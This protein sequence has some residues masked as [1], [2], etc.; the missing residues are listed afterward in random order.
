[1]DIIKCREC[2]TEN[3]KDFLY[4]KNCG[5]KL[6]F[7]EESAPKGNFVYEDF[8]P[9]ADDLGVENIN[10][11]PTDQI[12]LFVGKKAHY[13]LPKFNQMA[14]FGK[15]T[16]W[17]FA[18]SI[19]GLLFGP[20]GAALWCFYRKIYKTAFILLLVGIL[21]T[22]ITAALTYDSVTETFDF[23][24]SFSQ[25]EHEKDA[26]DL[27]EE[28]VPKETAKTALAQNIED[29][30]SLG[31]AI[32]MGLFANYIYMNH[33]TDSIKKYRNSGLD[34]RY[35]KLGLASLGGTSGG[36][37]ALGIIL[38]IGVENLSTIIV[39]TMHLLK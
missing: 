12:A 20:L 9:N 35:Y 30:F 29:V 27:L 26:L 17:N 5:A 28:F 37:L 33:C 23:I 16:S 25:K 39:L 15:K 2:G 14:I 7:D 38:F 19:L 24:L 34:Q 4:C 10:G 21:L 6:I 32:I 11:I 31:T 18:A 36:M 3:E 1:M 22:G 8:T 13:Y